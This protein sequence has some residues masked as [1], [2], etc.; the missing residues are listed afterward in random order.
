MESNW[1][2]VADM[3]PEL[4]KDGYS[5]DVLVALKWYDGDITYAVSWTYKGKWNADYENCKVIYWMPL[6]EKPCKSEEP[7]EH[8]QQWKRSMMN[9][10][11]GGR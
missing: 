8:E 1:I 2:P 7:K 11:L 4:D 5:D 6:P 9:T 3:L 10:F